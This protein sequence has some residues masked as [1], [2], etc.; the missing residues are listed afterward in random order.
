MGKLKNPAATVIDFTAVRGW[1]ADPISAPAI[2]HYMR[3][4]EMAK[5]IRKAVQGLIQIFRGWNSR[6]ILDRELNAMPDYIL[7]DI[8]IRRDEI[9]ALVAG[10]LQR[11]S[12]ALSPTGSQ[13]APAF[14]KDKGKDGTPL[15]A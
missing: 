15:A 3:Q 10:D 8:G 2:V 5:F 1:K 6:K 12:L 14:Y 7:Q 13:S 4:V 9:P 11:S